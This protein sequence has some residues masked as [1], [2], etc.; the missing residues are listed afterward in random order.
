MSPDSA[1]VSDDPAARERDRLASL[2]RFDVFDT[3]AERAFDDLAVLAA[4]VCETPIAMVC[5]VGDD[6]QAFKARVGL[7]LEGTAKD[8][9][10][11][12]HAIEQRCIRHQ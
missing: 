11:C 3:P 7:S 5:F 9:S 1:A 4:Q 6:R 12:A 2:R 10:F 8:I